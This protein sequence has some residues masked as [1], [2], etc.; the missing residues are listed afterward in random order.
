MEN[1]PFGHISAAYDSRTSLSSDS[2][3]NSDNTPFFATQG[4]NDSFAFMLNSNQYSDFDGNIP[5]LPV[6][7]P[8][9]LFPS[10]TDLEEWSLPLLE[11]N[12]LS[13]NELILE[14]LPATSNEYETVMDLDTSSESN[15]PSPL[16]SSFDSDKSTVDPQISLKY[17]RDARYP[18]SS[19]RY[20][21]DQNPVP[22]GLTEANQ[23]AT[24]RGKHRPSNLVISSSVEHLLPY[25]MAPGITRST[26]SPEEVKFGFNIT[27]P[28]TPSTISNTS[29][30]FRLT[31]ANRRFRCRLGTMSA[32]NLCHGMKPKKLQG[33]KRKES[34]EIKDEE[35][36]NNTCQ[37]CQRPFKRKHDLQR[38]VR[39]HTGEKPFQCSQCLLAF[40]R[41]DTLR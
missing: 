25:S 11:F 27:P 9:Q 21:P 15:M 7:E 4:L 40:S 8:L 14:C 41:T 38:H 17:S 13:G 29:S 2:T 19:I 16:S 34:V 24:F 30:F 37:F 39:L 1:E 18:L 10:S 23:A 35:A 6:T 22:D 5:P 26:T 12:E 32:K 31:K 3:L 33:K 20:I 36:E 28:L